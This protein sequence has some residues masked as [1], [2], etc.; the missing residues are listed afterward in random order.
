MLLL[1]QQEADDLIA[2]EKICETDITYHFPFQGDS[3]H[4]P[5]MSRDR[6]EDFLLDIYRG[7]I[8][9]MKVSYHNRVRKTIGLARIDIKG[10]PH[11]NPDGTV[12]PCPHIHLY[13]AGAALKWAEPLDGTN[14][15]IRSLLDNEAVLGDFMRFINVTK[16]PRLQFTL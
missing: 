10:A 15:G 16:A 3:L 7:R 8:D 9:I 1:T 11:E 4:I 5:L 6:R 14:Y 2:T 13:R 12:V